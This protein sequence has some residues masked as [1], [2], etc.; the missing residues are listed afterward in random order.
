MESYDAVLVD[1][2]GLEVCRAPFMGHAVIFL[3]VPES[4]PREA[5]LFPFHVNTRRFREFSLTGGA[6]VAG[7]PVY[8]EK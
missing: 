6:D 4:S 8:Q 1:R 7:R 2:D 5:V 3:E